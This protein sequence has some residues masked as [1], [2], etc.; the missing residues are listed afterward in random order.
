MEFAGTSVAKAARFAGIHEKEATAQMRGER[1]LSENLVASICMHVATRISAAA[2][3]AE[4]IPFADPKAVSSY[5]LATMKNLA[6]K[7]RQGHGKD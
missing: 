1:V 6:L 3:V 4:Q 5:A 7:H 2:W